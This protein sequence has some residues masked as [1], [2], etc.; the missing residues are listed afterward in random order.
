MNIYEY[1]LTKNECIYHFYTK[2][3]NKAQVMCCLG[4]HLFTTTPLTS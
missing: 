1:C 4:Y 2:K 3:Y